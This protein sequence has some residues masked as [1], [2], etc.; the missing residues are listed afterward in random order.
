MTRR[1][2]KYS[3][4]ICHA[5]TYD[6]TNNPVRIQFTNGSVSKYV[7][8]AT[9]EKLRVT[10]QTAVPNITVPIGS[11][12]ELLPSEVLSTDS[13]DY[14]LGGILT[15]RNLFVKPNE[16]SDACIGSALARK[17]RMKSNGRIDKFQFEEDYCK[18]TAYSG[19]TSQDTFSFSYY[20]RDHL[21][22]IR[23]VILALGNNGSSPKYH[24]VE[25]PDALY[26]AP[27]I[28]H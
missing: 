3:T 21:G 1:V 19:N 4:G 20:D 8:G 2:K 7:Y 5:C 12:R 16:Q 17:G 27:Q 9:G 10:Y 13:T 14:L 15:L 6:A 26:L 22:N 23:Q 25:E 18:A 28:H 24:H 11:A